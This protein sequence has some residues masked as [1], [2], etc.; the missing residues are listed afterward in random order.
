MKRLLI[1]VICVVAVMITSG[2]ANFVTNRSHYRGTDKLMRN[3]DVPAV[4][5]KL[6]K[7]K[8]RAYKQKDK[9][10]EYLDFGMLYHYQ[11]DYTQSNLLLEQADQSMEE[12]Y[13]KSVAKAALSLLLNDNA[14][15]YFGEDYEN[16]Y[17]NVFK[18]L[19]YLHQNKFDDAFVE[20][21]RIDEKLNALEDKYQKMAAGLNESKDKK[22]DIKIGTNRFINSALGRYLSMLIYEQEGKRDDAKLDYDKLLFAFDSQPDIYTFSPPPLFD[23][24]NQMDETYLHVI[25]LTGKSPVKESR[26]LHI[27]T[28]KDQLT[29]VAVGED[30]TPEII[31]WPGIEPDYYFKFAVPLI[32]NKDTEIARVVVKVDNQSY[33]LAKIEDIGNVAIQTFKVKAPLIYLKSITRTVVKGLLAEE[34]K[35]QMQKKNPDITGDLMSLATDIA[36]FASENADLRISHF[37]PNNV[38]ISDIPVSEGEHSIAIEYYHSNGNLLYRDDKGFVNVSKDKL[39]LIESWEHR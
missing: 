15:D 29:I 3:R 38:L 39:N 4:I 36:L 18:A 32:V 14:L 19:N 17:T 21:R 8:K 33:D 9:V 7:S 5:K 23:P 30:I 1:A 31:F 20:I 10:L 16:I 22:Q 34:A 6:E 28:S 12:L 25:A 35:K 13:T 26:E 27:V 11:G 24:L 37:F 2:C